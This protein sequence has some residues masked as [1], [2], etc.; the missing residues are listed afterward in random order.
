MA[1]HLLPFLL[2]GFICDFF[3]FG[4]VDVWIKGMLRLEI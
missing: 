3:F 2:L 1:K 4:V